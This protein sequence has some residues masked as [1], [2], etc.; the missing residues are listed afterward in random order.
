MLIKETSLKFKV[1]IVPHT[2]IARDFSTPLSA[3]DRSWKQKL[4]RDTVRLTE[5]MSQMDLTDIYRTFHPKDL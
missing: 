2:I 4:N 3:M 5:V 1:H